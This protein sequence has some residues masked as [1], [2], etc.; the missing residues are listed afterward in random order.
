MSDS[1]SLLRAAVNAVLCDIRLDN[2]TATT[3]HGRAIYKVWTGKVL[4]ERL[5]IYSRSYCSNTPAKGSDLAIPPM[6]IGL[7]N[8]KIRLLEIDTMN[9]H[10]IR[11]AI[12]K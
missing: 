2:Y 3:Q 7:L 5:L 11:I 1:A 12:L 4:S 10:F 6:T 9:M 8:L